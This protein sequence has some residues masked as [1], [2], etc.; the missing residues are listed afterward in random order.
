MALQQRPPCP[1]CLLRFCSIEH[2]SNQFGSSPACCWVLSVVPGVATYSHAGCRPDTSVA[3]SQDVLRTSSASGNGS[4]LR[5][6]NSLS[7][8]S[9]AF[10]DAQGPITHC[11]H[12]ATGRFANA[13]VAS[14]DDFGCAQTPRRAQTATLTSTC[15]RLTLSSPHLSTLDTS[16]LTGLP[17]LTSSSLL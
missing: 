3:V 13:S 1:Q 5:V 16:M 11:L 4:N 15:R 2:C 10:C 14:F 17:R 6:T 12:A 9:A 8:V 7:Q